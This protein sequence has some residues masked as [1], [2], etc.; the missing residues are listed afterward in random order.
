MSPADADA[1]RALDRFLDH[2]PL[3]EEKLRVR[4]TLVRDATFLA[5]RPELRDFVQRNRAAIVRLDT[6][7]RHLLYRA[8]LRQASAPL[9]IRE[10]EVFGDLLDQEPVLERALNEN[11]E[12]IRDPEFL[13]RQPAL[14]DFLFRRP[15]LAAAFSTPSSTEKHD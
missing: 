11:P 8:L 9:P 1:T 2:H 15:R 14:R 6:D 3:L 10:V 7:P 4:P 13:K 12:S 5:Q